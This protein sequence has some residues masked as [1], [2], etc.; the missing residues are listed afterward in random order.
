MFTA[1]WGS[2]TLADLHQ[3][4]WIPVTE[5]AVMFAIAGLIWVG[6]RVFGPAKEG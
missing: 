6:M 2:R 4:T 1:V 5:Y 3:L